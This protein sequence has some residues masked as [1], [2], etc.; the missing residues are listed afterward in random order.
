MDILGML[1][2]RVDTSLQREGKK[3]KKVKAKTPGVLRR[4]TR[5]EKAHKTL[6]SVD[7]P[8]KSENHLKSV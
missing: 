1:E 3:K 4:Y 7:S 6:V 8:E 2:I 5:S